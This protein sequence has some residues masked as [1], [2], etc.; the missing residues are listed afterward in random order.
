MT[1]EDIVISNT[2]V[3]LQSLS[4]GNPLTNQVQQRLIDLCFM[5]FPVDGQ[6]GAVSKLALRQFAKA[7]GHTV[8]LTL[9]PA[10]AKALIESDVDTLLPVTPKSDLAG[11]VFRYMRRKNYWFA[12]L[13]K[14][15]NIVYIEG[16]NKDGALN[17]DAPNKFNDRRIVITVEDG[18][19]VEKGN[20]QATTEPGRTY[21]ISPLVSLGAARIAFGQFKAWNVGT[22]MANKPGAHEALRQVGIIRIHR[23]LNKDYK[24]TGDAEFEGSSYAINQHYGYDHPE[25]NIGSASAGCLVGRL[26]EEHRTFMKLIKTDPRYVASN[27]YKFITTVIAGDDL[28]NT[29][30]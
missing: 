23:D 11:R 29:I 13:P 26:K 3:N 17:D 12:R 1:L 14:Y 15:L 28:K 24:R 5:D 4:L 20:W 10:V 8:D 27:G 16:A 21:T 22:H 6:F 9:E 18:V 7:V 19:P 25:D 2:P 30:G